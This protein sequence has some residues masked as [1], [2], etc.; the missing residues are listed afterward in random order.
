MKKLTII[1][2]FVLASC[3]NVRIEDI[4]YPEANIL[5]WHVPQTIN[6][7]SPNSAF[8]AYVWVSRH[9]TSLDVEIVAM[10]YAMAMEGMLVAEF[11]VE[12]TKAPYSCPV[13]LVRFSLKPLD[14]GLPY[15]Q[16]YKL[17]FTAKNN[18]RESFAV[19]SVEIKPTR[20]PNQR[21]KP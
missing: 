17:K 4:V 15:P 5:S 19:V 1:L 21:Y 6:Q 18:H 8:D 20:L 2:A 12:V 9:T 14:N 16:Y 13:S 11:T 3:T 10:P 7:D